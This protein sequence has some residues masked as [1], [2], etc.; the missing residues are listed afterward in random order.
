MIF[1]VYQVEYESY[2]IMTSDIR[3]LPCYYRPIAKF[4]VRTKD[5]KHR[6]NVYFPTCYNTQKKEPK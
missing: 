6:I 5:L 3:S 4:R 1:N 2:V